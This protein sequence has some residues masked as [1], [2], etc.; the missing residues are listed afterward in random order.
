[1]DLEDLGDEGSGA[2][3]LKGDDSTKFYLKFGVWREQQ[4]VLDVGFCV[5]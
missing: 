2:P 3:W 5:L 4:P 1:V